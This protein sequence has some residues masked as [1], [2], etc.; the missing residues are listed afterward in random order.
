MGD[1]L[2]VSTVSAGRIYMAQKRNLTGEDAQLSWERMP[3]VALSKVN[4]QVLLT[5]Y[6]ACPVYIPAIIRQPFHSLNV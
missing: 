4:L 2:G 5:L 6:A 1:G 3:H